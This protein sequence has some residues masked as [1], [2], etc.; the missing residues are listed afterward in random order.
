MNKLNKETQRMHKLKATLAWV[1]W[2]IV[3]ETLGYLMGILTEH[4]LS[5][6]YD[7]LIKSSLTPPGIVFAIVWPILYILLATVGYRLFLARSH[8]PKRTKQL[9]LVQLLLNYLW[10]PAFFGMHWTGIALLLLIAMVVVSAVLIVKFLSKQKGLVLTF[11]PY[12]L[13]ICFATYL[14]AFTW[15]HN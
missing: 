10:T 9:F 13:W 3:L 4:N 7:S 6:W 8:T 15:I 12:F 1:G 2:L 14:N 11:L 5:P